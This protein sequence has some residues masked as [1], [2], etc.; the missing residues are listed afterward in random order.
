MTGR[1]RQGG[2]A[3]RAV[4][5]AIASYLPEHQLTNEDLAREYPDWEPQKIFS[6][7]GIRVR[8]IAAPGECA[9]DLGVA[10]A[11]RLFETASCRRGDIDFLL[12]CTQSPDYFLPATA[13]TMQ[14][15]LGLSQNCGALDFNQGCSGFVYGLSLARGLIDSDAAGNVLLVTAETYSKYLDSNDRSTRTIFGDGA[16]AAVITAVDDAEELIG[17]FVFGTDGRGAGE[18]IV[19]TGAMRN[20][21]STDT[22]AK[23]GTAP[24]HRTLYMNGPEVFNFTIRELPATI[25]R[26]LQKARLRLEEINYFVFH[27]ANEFMLEHLRKKLSIPRQKFCIN[28]ESYGNTVSSTI[29]MALEIAMCRNQ[30]KTGDRVMIVG[31]GVGFSWAAAMIK[32]I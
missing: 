16:S 22:E 13:C 5:K 21:A 14:S 15:R 2:G 3:K 20:P 26:L 28:L 32:L 1:A 30:V 11:E 27:Q 6:K 25:D 7:T 18:L 23:I 8:H 4:L 29:P 24:T 9:S 17:P 19:R 10:A 31:F 12:F